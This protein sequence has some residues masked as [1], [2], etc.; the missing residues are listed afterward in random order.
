MFKKV[1]TK[2]Y[3]VMFK[4]YPYAVV[5]KNKK[6]DERY[7][8]HHALVTSGDSGRLLVRPTPHMRAL[9]AL[10]LRQAN[11]DTTDRQSDF[12]YRCSFSH[13]GKVYVISV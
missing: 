4:V 7:C 8:I 5:L 2:V 1:Y 9:H 11:T 10:S 13:T 3:I 12:H 6:V